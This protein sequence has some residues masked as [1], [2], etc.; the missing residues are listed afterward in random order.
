MTDQSLLQRYQQVRQQSLQ[1]CEPLVVEDFGF[2]R[3]LLQ[4]L[5]NGIWRI[6]AGFLK[7]FC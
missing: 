2:R 1:A 7:H 6:P 3:R 4:V 5:P